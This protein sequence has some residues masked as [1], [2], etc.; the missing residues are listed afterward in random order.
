MA[1]GTFLNEEFLRQLTAVGEVDLLVGI[2]TFNDAKTIQH[3]IHA[4]QIGLVKYFPRQRTV[5]IN[6]DGGSRDGTPEVV[7]SST[8]PDFRTVLATA[9]LRTMHTVTAKYRAGMG[10]GEAVRLIFAA[11]DLL[12]AKACAIISSDLLSITPEW[13]DALLRPVYREGF[14]FLTPIYERHKFD[15]LLIK[16]ILSPV[17]RGAYGCEIREPVGGEFGFSGALACQFLAQDVW[18]E[19]FVQYGW[20]LWMTTMALSG[21]YR[22]CQSFLGPKIH[23]EKGAGESLPAT[24]QR[25]VGALFRS[26]EIHESF[27]VVRTG[28]KTAPTFGFQAEL[29]LAAVRVNRKRMFQM[30][31]S[32]V[33]E[34]SSILEQILSTPT[35]QGIREI[36]NDTDAGFRFPDEL[37]VKT[38]Y[39]FAAAYHHSVINRDHL[40]QALTPV[41]RGRVG[42]YLLENHG[43]SVSEL[44]ERLNSLNVEF[45][46]L[47]P[48]L[49][50]CWRAKT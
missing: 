39:E 47:K 7:K 21:G 5:L 34:L 19:E 25:I 12:R 45:E 40:L 6:P 31:R 30:F 33:E 22:L 32:G 1:E 20:P 44:T 9:P 15:A 3:V 48:Y 14:D 49:I 36:A 4:V 17:I 38:I 26:M 29:D 37:W 18:H 2:V 28:L 13:V 10:T 11:A 35:A 50:E 16:N 46:R 41:Y 8:I 43:A 24:I 42:A 27:W 23:S